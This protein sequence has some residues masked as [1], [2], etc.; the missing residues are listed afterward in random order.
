[1]GGRDAISLAYY[2]AYLVLLPAGQPEEIALVLGR[3]DELE[4]QLVA[5]IERLASEVR[6]MID[7]I[8][9]D[10]WRDRLNNRSEMLERLEEGVR[11]AN[12]PPPPRDA[13]RGH[14]G[15]P[16]ELARLEAESWVRLA[17]QFKSSPFLSDPAKALR[18]ADS[19]GPEQIAAT[20]CVL[21]SSEVGALSQLRD[22]ERQWQA[23]W[24]LVSP[25]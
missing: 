14:R 2:R 6:Q 3:T 13:H 16:S 19:S 1:M 17:E 15:Q 20:V 5:H 23:K 11:K 18:A 9:Q 22:L 7:A 4:E 8:P 12:E 10:I 24:R 25:G 21:V